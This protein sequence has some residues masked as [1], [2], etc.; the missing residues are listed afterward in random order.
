[1]QGVKIEECA[2]DSNQHPFHNTGFA[3]GEE[4]RQQD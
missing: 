2:W 3:S 4:E 1:M